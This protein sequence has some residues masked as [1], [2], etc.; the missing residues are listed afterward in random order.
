MKLK[1][2]QRNTLY[3]HEIERIL[4]GLACGIQF[5]PQRAELLKNQMFRLNLHFKEFEERLNKQKFVRL[6]WSLGKLNLIQ[7]Q[8]YTSISEV[9]LSSESQ[10]TNLE[11]INVK[12][13]QTILESFR[14]YFDFG[15]YD[16]ELIDALFTSLMEQTKNERRVHPSILVSLLKTINFARYY[17]PKVLNWLYTEV[18]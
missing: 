3:P 14:H 1:T 17:N 5:L 16:N 7:T 8:F 6:M 18:V 9:L 4:T 2:D 13:I 12:D 10:N 11:T 15:S